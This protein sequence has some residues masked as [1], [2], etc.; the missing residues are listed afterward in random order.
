MGKSYWE[1]TPVLVSMA[2]I[3]TF[4]W[5]SAFPCIKIGYA[6]FGIGTA[7]TAGQIIFAGV[8][9]TIAGI[10]VIAAASF[11]R[12]HFATVKRSSIKHVIV[13]ALTQTIGQYFLF[14]VG[15]AHASGVSSSLIS[16]ANTFITILFAALIFRT[17]KMT[18]RK[19]VGCLIGFAGVALIEVPW[20]G[21]GAGNFGFSIAGEGAVLLSTVSAALAACYIKY[22]GKE[23]DPMALSGWQFILGGIFLTLGSLAAGG[24]LRLTGQEGAMERIGV[25]GSLLY[26]ASGVSSGGAHIALGIFLLLYMAFIS[27]CAYTLW[28]MLLKYNP[29]S[30]VAVFSFVN[31]VVGVMLS[32]LLLGETNQAFSLAGIGALA[33]VSA[34]IVIVN[35]QES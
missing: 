33:L 12:G 13:L 26:A 15:L 6:F 30:R 23:E 22:A 8:R 21:N 1:K 31:P 24:R 32:A 5:G 20:Q 16:A 9:F 11:M 17:E 7:D 14:Y 2:L 34:G 35:R 19:V 18:V 27:A 3:A 28:S 25:E 4:L 10:M 29:V